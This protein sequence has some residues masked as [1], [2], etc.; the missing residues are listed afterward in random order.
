MSFL[1]FGVIDTHSGIESLNVNAVKVKY[2]EYHGIRCRKNYR[3]PTKVPYHPFNYRMAAA[4]FIR[5]VSRHGKVTRRYWMKP[6]TA[7]P[8]VKTV[9]LALLSL[10]LYE[11]EEKS[12]IQ[13]CRSLSI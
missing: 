12:E 6:L 4:I 10:K 8:G 1:F 3:L 5:V 13:S 11:I 7:P 9:E 2:F